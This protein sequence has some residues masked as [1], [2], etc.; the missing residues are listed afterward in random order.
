MLW[1][2]RKQQASANN[3]LRLDLAIVKVIAKSMMIY[4][5]YLVIARDLQQIEEA[6]DLTWRHYRSM[7]D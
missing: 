5:Q 6:R 3:G 1:I 4:I 7:R 2:E